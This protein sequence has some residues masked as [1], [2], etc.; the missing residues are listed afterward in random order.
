MSTNTEVDAWFASWFD[1]PYYH[2]L[3]RDRGYEEARA[4]VKRMTSSLKLQQGATIMDLACGRGRHSLFLNTLGYDV[5]GVDL[6]P[7]S[8]AFAKATLRT[9]VQ[10]DTKINTPTDLGYLDPSHIRFNVHNMTMPYKKQFDAVF[11]LFT[12]F[13]YFEDEADNLRTIIA[14]KKN[15]NENG[16][17]VID[18]MNAPK[19]LKNLVAQDTKTEDGIAFHQKRYVKNDHIYKEITFK[20]KDRDYGFTERVHALTLSQFEAYFNKAGLQL[21]ACYGNYNLEPYNETT[22]DRLIMVLKK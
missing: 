1:T 19:V 20:D 2:I 17:A 18:F 6:S 7:S 8:I 22:S 10:K 5:T 13:G 9:A 12:S 11:N 4:F 14:I 15:L 16:H 21:T 3:Y